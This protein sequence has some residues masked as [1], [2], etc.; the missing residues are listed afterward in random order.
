MDLVPYRPATVR[1]VFG[2]GREFER[3]VDQLLH[4][5]TESSDM[6]TNHWLPPVDLR[7]TGD[8]VEIWA[9]VPGMTRDDVEILME[10]DRL[11]IRGERK[12]PEMPEGDVNWL[13]SE[14]FQGRFHRTFTLPAIVDGT[15]AEARYENGVLCIT[16]PKREEARPLRVDIRKS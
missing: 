15:K 14:R 8:A 6:Q 4:N 11:T 13:A 9:D 2:L 7:V 16:I 3:A 5:V 10:G 12:P 1:S